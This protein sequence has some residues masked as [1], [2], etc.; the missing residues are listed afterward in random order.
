MTEN[1]WTW[2]GVFFLGE[3]YKLT[4]AEM[5]PLFHFKCVA[6]NVTVLCGPV[7]K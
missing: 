6:A 4:Q 5:F 3:W 7:S 1:N 2:E